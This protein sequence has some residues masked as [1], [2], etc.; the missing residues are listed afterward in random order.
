MS[1]KDL[2]EVKYKIEMAIVEAEASEYTEE[3][4]EEFINGYISGLKHSLL[5]INDEE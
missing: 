5:F 4:G 2:E 1:K 3:Y